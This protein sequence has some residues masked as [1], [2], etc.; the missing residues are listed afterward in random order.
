MS[1]LFSKSYKVPILVN[2]K[3]IPT[4]RICP[5]AIAPTNAGMLSGKPGILGPT[6]GCL[7]FKA[8]NT[9]NTQLALIIAPTVGLH[10][11]VAGTVEAVSKIDEIKFCLLCHTNQAVCSELTD[12]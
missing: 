12:N 5:K 3:T 7:T 1:F 11:G 10:T 8:S 6:K 9:A 2:P 4:P